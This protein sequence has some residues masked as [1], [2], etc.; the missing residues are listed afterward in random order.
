[1]LIIE[2]LQTRDILSARE[3]EEEIH[4]IEVEESFDRYVSKKKVFFFFSFPTNILPVAMQS[5]F[6]VTF[7][8]FYFKNTGQT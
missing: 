5:T 2:F 8:I 6:R 1:M 7:L 3:A 4:L